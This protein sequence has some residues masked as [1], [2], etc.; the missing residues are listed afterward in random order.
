MNIYQ[1]DW[2]EPIIN[3][4]KSF[5][6]IHFTPQE[7]FDYIVQMI[8]ETEDLLKNPVMGRAYLEEFGEYKDFYRIVVRKFRIYYKEINNK[9]VIAAVQIPG[10][11]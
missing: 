11:G 7:S 10:E 3:K 4:L 8:M 6:S 5:Q 9:I 2:P 1:V